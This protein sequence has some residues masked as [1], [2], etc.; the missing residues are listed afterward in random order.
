MFSHSLGTGEKEKIGE[1]FCGGGIPHFLLTNVHKCDEYHMPR[2][3]RKIKRMKEGRR[4][5]HPDLRCMLC[6]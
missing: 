5:I 6:I 1:A 4:N 2:E 3:C